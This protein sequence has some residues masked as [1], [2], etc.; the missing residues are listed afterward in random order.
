MTEGVLGIIGC[1]MLEDNLIHCLKDDP[2][3]KDI[4]IIENENIGPLRRKLEARGIPFRLVGMDDVLAGRYVPTEGAFNLLVYEFSLGKHAYPDKLKED[5]EDVTGKLQPYVD[6]IGFYLG[7]CGNFDWDIPR[8]CESE[9]YKPSAMFCDADGNLCHDCVGVAIA[10]GPRYLE[11]EKRYPGCMFM[12]PSMVINYDEFMLANNRESVEATRRLT[13]D[14]MEALGIE[15]GEDG[16][17][18]W[19]LS[20]GNYRHLLKL[21]NGIGDEDG[22]F[23]EG[24]EKLKA[25]MRLDVM[26]AEPGWAS[27]QP[28]VD[29][30][31]KCKMM[32]DGAHGS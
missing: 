9:G 26:D 31:R 29:L 15:P 11:M 25:R 21:D 13:P 18:R 23:D 24:L 6:A 30:Y 3:A 4:A 12:F 20:L 7:T 17:M 1:P 28:T 8:W 5:V 19:L 14:M 27:T 10:G 22:G 2:D 16:Y 32:L